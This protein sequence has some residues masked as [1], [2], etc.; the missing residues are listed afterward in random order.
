MIYLDNAATSLPKPDGVIQAV[1][2]ALRGFGN[3]ARGAH[4]PSLEAART[5]YRARAKLCALFG[6]PSPSRVV[7]TPNI[8]QA[9]NMALGV[10][11]AGDHVITTVFEHNSVLRP[12]HRC[13]AEI[14]FLAPDSGFRWEYARFEEA[15]RP[16]TVAVVATHASNVTGDMLDIARIGTICRDRGVRFIVDTA[17]TAGIFPIDMREMHIDILCFTGHK[18]LLGPQGIGGLCLAEDVALP[19]L[20]VGGTGSDSFSPEQPSDLPTA[21]EAGTL[22][23]PGIAGLLAGLEY[24]EKWGMDTLREQEM[25]LAWAFTAALAKEKRIVLYGDHAAERAPVVALNIRGL[26][27][28]EVAARLYE[29]YGVCVRAGAHCAP[30]THAFLGTRESGAVRFSFSCLNTME[31]ARTAAEAVL[32]LAREE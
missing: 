7:F 8:T 14:S 30:R 26:D 15:I 11:G 29:E 13:G 1:E 6:A 22:N 24:I 16:E 3:P 21:L 19:A 17:Q 20:V 25:R 12:L 23:G 5:V 4:G 31:E 32:A 10:Y 28:A 18:A 2:A 9:L 27:A